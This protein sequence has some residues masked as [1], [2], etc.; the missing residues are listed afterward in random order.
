M[1]PQVAF[2]GQAGGN[3]EDDLGRRHPHANGAGSGLLQ[4]G[5]GLSQS[6]LDGA[7]QLDLV[8]LVDPVAGSLPGGAPISRFWR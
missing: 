3:G 8:G 4:L 1:Q 6:G 7:N 5:A 2:L